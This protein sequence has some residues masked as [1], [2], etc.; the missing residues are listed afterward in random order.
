MKKTLFGIAAMTGLLLATSCS[1]EDF[2]NP[3][4]KAGTIQFNVGIEQSLGTRALNDGTEATDLYWAI[5]NAEGTQ[6]INSGTGEISN[7]NGMI[8]Q[9]LQPG[10]YRFAAWA[11]NPNVPEGVYDLTNLLAVG[12]DFSKAPNND[13]TL[14]A[15]CG[16]STFE[17]DGDGTVDV[18]LYRPFAQVNFGWAQPVDYTS[19]SVIISGDLASNINIA[20]NV[21]SGSVEGQLELASNDLLNEQLVLDI[22]GKQQ[23]FTYLSMNYLLV[24][25]QGTINY[26][27]SLNDGEQSYSMDNVPVKTN[28]RTNILGDVQKGEVVF[29]IE[30]KPSYDGD[31]NEFMYAEPVEISN[32][33]AALNEEGDAVNLSATYKPEDATIY[34]ASFM[35]IPKAAPALLLSPNG[36]ITVEAEGENGVLTAEVPLSEL[37]PGTEYFITAKINNSEYEPGEDEDQPEFTVPS[38]DYPSQLYIIGSAL[39]GSSWQYGILMEMAGDGQYTIENITMTSELSYFG[40]TSVALDGSNWDEVN[41][42]RWGAA[43]DGAAALLDGQKNAMEMNDNTWTVANG[44]YTINVDLATLTMTI[45]KTGDY[46]PEVPELPIPETLYIIGTVNGTNWD[47]AFAM[48]TKSSGV[49]TLE[50]VVMNDATS[51]FS[52]TSVELDGSN[53]NGANGVNINRWVPAQNDAPV[54]VGGG[55]NAMQ[56][57]DREDGGNAWMVEGGIY[58]I[59]VDLNELT[60]TMERTSEA[61][62]YDTIYVVGDGD[63]MTWDLPGQEITGSNNIF[64]FTINNGASFKFST[65][66]VNVTGDTTADWNSF[67]SGA[68]ATGDTFFSNSVLNSSGQTLSIKSWGENQRLPWTGTYNITINLTTME[69][70]AFTETPEPTEPEA[71]YIVGAMTGWGIDSSYKMDWDSAASSS[72]GATVYTWTGTIPASQEFKIAGIKSNG[73]VDWGSAVN[74]SSQSTFTVSATGTTVNCSYNVSGN[75][76]LNAAFTGTVTLKVTSPT[77]ATLTFTPSA[78]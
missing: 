3:A 65:V 49:Y 19:S 52:F 6:I 50:N 45:T 8:A 46:T 25:G 67:N 38:S 68:Y 18:K 43:E 9:E 61:P 30:I 14:D 42:S 35:L 5:T 73:A 55:T 32:V 41:A 58:T 33:K 53:W 22:N 24:A 56:A 37:T 62:T 76:K 48:T 63:G 10:S 34:N 4:G 72:S 40:F 70:T 64:T 66:K 21:V 11:Q 60:F 39:N 7:L 27:V 2:A 54:V 59:N 17:V 13:T 23:T 16:F 75:M 15:F 26:E 69:M 51:Y 44:I 57:N 71:A 28:W 20:T 31:D 12:V 1:N 29:N 74:W 47:G 77:A 36:A 78:Q